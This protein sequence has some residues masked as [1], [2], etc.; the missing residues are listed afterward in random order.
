MLL[1]Q[2]FWLSQCKFLPQSVQVFRLEAMTVSAKDIPNISSWKL[3]KSEQAELQARISQG[4]DAA[5]AKR[6]IQ[7]RKALA[8]EERKKAAA[9]IASK[10][11]AADPKKKAAKAKAKAVADK[12][13]GVSDA[14]GTD[15]TNAAYYADIEADLKTI[16][17][18]FPNLDKEMPLALKDSETDRTKSGVQEPYNVTKGKNALSLHGVYRCSIP[19]FWVQILAS[20]TPGIPMSRRRVQDMAAF[21]FPEGTPQ[22]LTGRMAEVAVHKESLTEEPRNLQM[23]SPEEI[24]H[25]L[26]A[27][28]ADSIRCLG[29]H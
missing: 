14:V 23:I 19:L 7:T 1:Q 29:L 20:P 24:V 21:Y 17:K 18:E 5:E 11:A 13:E 28:C 9:A 25:S 3:N 15:P 10:P 8:C 2:L 4:E 16:L 27:A 6:D 12:A 26:V 22:F